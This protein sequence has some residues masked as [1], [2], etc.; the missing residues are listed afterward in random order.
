VYGENRTNT[1]CNKAKDCTS[2]K[3]QHRQVSLT[4]LAGVK[5]AC[6]ENFKVQVRIMEARPGDDPNMAFIMRGK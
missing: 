1:I 4:S 6:P 5:G 3:C 2:D